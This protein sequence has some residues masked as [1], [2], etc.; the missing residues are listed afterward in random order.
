MR[1]REDRKESVLKGQKVM[2]GWREQTNKN[3]KKKV[4]FKSSDPHT[5]QQ[6]NLI[7]R[8]LGVMLGA[9]Y[10]LHRHKVLHSAVINTHPTT[11]T[12][13]H[14]RARTHTRG[15]SKSVSDGEVVQCFSSCHLNM[16]CKYVNVLFFT[17][18]VALAVVVEI[19]TL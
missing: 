4:Q 18:R 6:F 19:H 10:H 14:A 7:Q 15:L 8:C 16:V 1:L 13:A 17:I 12:H 3:K 11:C 5:S 9:L 2:T